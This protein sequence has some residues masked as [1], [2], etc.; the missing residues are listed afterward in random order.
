MSKKDNHLNEAL[1][2]LAA[3][4]EQMKVVINKLEAHVRFGDICPH[5]HK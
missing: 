5:T 1:S 3:L 2:R 4:E